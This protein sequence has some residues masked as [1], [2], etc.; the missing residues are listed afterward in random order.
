MNIEILGALVIIVLSSAIFI[1]VGYLADRCHEGMEV[2]IGSAT[3]V[4][5]SGRWERQFS[6]AEFKKL[7]PSKELCDMIKKNKKIKVNGDIAQAE[8]QSLHTGK[9]GGSIPSIATNKF[10]TPP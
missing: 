8:E 6:D 2:K 4:K 5:K 7:A 10:T 1:L 9:V 3:F